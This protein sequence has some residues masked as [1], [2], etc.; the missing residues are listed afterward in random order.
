M[1]RTGPMIWTAAMVALALQASSEPLRAQG[2]CGGEGAAVQMQT[3][4]EK[5]IFSVD[6]LWLTLRL[7]GETARQLRDLAARRPLTGEAADSVARIAVDA[8][9]AVAQLDFVRDVSRDQF[10][11]GIRDSAR[12]AW[13]AGLLDEETYHF[14]DDAST[15]WYPFLRERGV[16]EGDRMTYRIRGDTLRIQY[17]S[18]DGETLLDDREVG[19]GRSRSVLAGYFAP[20]SD[21]REGLVE[22]LFDGDEAAAITPEGPPGRRP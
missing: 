19:E 4:L 5:T 6:V 15:S 7:E 10:L 3:L 2:A 12:K 20:D 14:I 18:A 16:R 9:C 11:D 21:F 8:R 17:R 22:D 1:H 13:E